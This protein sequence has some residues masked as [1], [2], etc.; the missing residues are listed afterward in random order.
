LDFSTIE[1]L[2]NTGQPE[3]ALQQIQSVEKSEHLTTTDRLTL[4]LLASNAFNK[5]GDFKK[6]LQLAESVKT[7]SQDV[8]N[9]LLMI[10]ACIVI[11]E[12]LEHLGRFDEKIEVIKIAEKELKTVVDVESTDFKRRHS[13]ILDQQ[14]RIHWWKGALDNA[15]GFFQQ[16]LR[17]REELQNDYLI[18]ESF[19]NLGATFWLQ[20]DINQAL[21]YFELS[22]TLNKRHQNPPGIATSLNNIG[23]IHWQKGELDDALAY[24]QQSLTLFEELANNQDIAISLGNIGKIYHDKGDFE[25][26]LE[27]HER[28]LILRADVENAQQI[29]MSLFELISVTLDQGSLDVAQEYLQNLQQ[30]DSLEK[31]KIIS[32]QYRV[33]RALF[34]KKRGTTRERGKAEMLLEQVA[35]EDVCRYQ[36]TVTALLNLCELLL[37]EFRDNEDPDILKEVQRLNTRLFEI[38]TEQNSHKLIAEVYLLRSKLALLELKIKDARKFLTQAQRIAETWGLNRLA[39]KISSEHDQLLRQLNQ[40]EEAVH[41]NASLRERIA[42]SQLEEMIG[43][44]VRKNKVKMPPQRP[45]EPVML[46]IVGKSGLSLFSRIFSESQINDQLLGGFLS[47]ISSFGTEVLE[48]TET[49][50]RIMYQEHTLAL[51]PLDSLMFTY[52]FKG[53][54][55]SALQK[56]DRFT[57]T[58]HASTLAWKGL[59]RMVKTGKTLKNSEEIAIVDIANGIFIVSAS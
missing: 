29:A 17:L 49:L 38:G 58:V 47:A 15:L 43:G 10:D 26:A 13:S 18:T 7:E 37:T 54:S 9:S 20:G 55:Y 16:S 28:S 27:H 4:Q 56:L 5:Q 34:L 12:A 32:H 6:A 25:L 19:T 3:N 41:R 8:N 31:K 44:M 23:A 52:I 53:P 14:G 51:K 46:L 24:Y 2:L 40:W 45:K 39:M 57:G 48:A 59:T 30:I 33:A 11:A 35:E 36:L 1:K 50:D 21:V 22:L 42:L